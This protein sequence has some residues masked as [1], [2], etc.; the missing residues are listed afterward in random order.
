M[1]ALGDKFDAFQ[2]LYDQ[3]I[4]ARN[5]NDYKLSNDFLRRALPLCIELS[6]EHPNP[7]FKKDFLNKIRDIK[8]MINEIPQKK[9]IT[10]S[11]SESSELDY[12]KVFIPLSKENNKTTFADVA[13]LENVKK[14]INDIIIWPLQH[15]EVYKQ[16]DINPGGCVLMF[17]PPGTGK[18]TIAKAIANEVNANYYLVKNEQVIDKYVGDIEK[19]IAG[20]FKEI[21][22]NK[23]AVVFFDDTDSLI[24]SRDSDDKA[25]KSSV[26]TLITEIDGIGTDLENILLLI[27]TNRPWNVDQ[28]LLSRCS[29]HIYVTLPDLHARGE[30][31][32]L[33]LK[34]RPLE[35]NIDLIKIAQ[36]S[37]GFSGREIKQ[38]CDQVARTLARRHIETGVIQKCTTEI[39]IEEIQNKLKSHS[40]V[41]LQQFEDFLLDMQNT[42]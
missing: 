25:S 40:S 8:N 20:L 9:V 2:S 19:K 21:R 31:F 14:A 6:S 41:K 36:I 4:A 42:H 17:G 3:G 26:S 23:P 35:S 22:K 33:N 24:G 1:S 18:T 38:V 37:E 13:G 39:V 7:T 34:N 30:I 27:G 16:Y 5:N 11:D 32:Y 28:A 29:E 15:K 12:S 10:T